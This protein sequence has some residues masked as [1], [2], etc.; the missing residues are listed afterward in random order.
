MKFS[1]AALRGDMHEGGMILGA[2]RQFLSNILP[3]Q[4]GGH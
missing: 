4:P 3:G 1:R 2:A